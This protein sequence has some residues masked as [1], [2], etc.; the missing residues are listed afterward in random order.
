MV[1]HDDDDEEEECCK[2]LYKILDMSYVTIT[3]YPGE[4]VVSGQSEP[5]VGVR[6]QALPT[7]TDTYD[8]DSGE[9]VRLLTRG[10]RG[11]NM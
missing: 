4:G 9:S 1:V 11:Q 7:P 10:R 8:A 3:N 6:T 2:Y 5:A